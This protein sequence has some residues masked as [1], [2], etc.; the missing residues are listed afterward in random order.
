MC[1]AQAMASVTMSTDQTMGSTA[2][3]TSIRGSTNRNGALAE[4]ANAGLGAL[5][6]AATVLDAN[7]TNKTAEQTQLLAERDLMNKYNANQAR[8]QQEMQKAQLQQVEVQQRGYSN[9][10]RIRA[11]VASGGISGHTAAERSAQPG[12]AAENFTA[13]SKQNLANE[14]RQNQLDAQSYLAQAQSTVNEAQ[15]Q[16]ISAGAEALSIVGSV[17]KTAEAATG[18][19][20]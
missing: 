7:A 3:A 11:Q 18:G 10:S 9:A 4:T 5:S 16:K 1:D 19:A 8:E 14:L 17:A 12:I 2:P 20:G 15:S 6:V 13:A